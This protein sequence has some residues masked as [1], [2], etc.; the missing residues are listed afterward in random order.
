MHLRGGAQTDDPQAAEV[1]LTAAT[2]AKRIDARADERFLGGSE[3][4]AAAATEALDL[5]K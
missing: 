4:L 5:L 3:Q 1:T 2:I